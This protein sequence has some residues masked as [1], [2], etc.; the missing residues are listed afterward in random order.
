[1]DNI[2]YIKVLVFVLFLV[3]FMPIKAQQY[4]LTGV[5]TDSVTHEALSYVNVYLKGTKIGTKTNSDGEFILRTDMKSAH[6]VISSV[7]YKEF[8]RNINPAK[9]FRFRVALRPSNVTLK[10][11][12]I[13]PKREHYKKKDNPAVAFVRQMMAHKDDHSPDNHDYWSRNRYEKTLFALN[14]FTEDMQKKWIYR[15]FPFLLDYVDTS[16]VTGK[17]VLP[18]TIR[19]TV[20]SDYYRKSPNSLKQLIEAKKHAGIDEILSQ[21]G[22]E[23]TVS[24]V[25]RDVDIYKDNI[26]LFTNKF[27]SPLSRLGVD[28]Y[29]YYL[30]DTLQVDHEKCVDLAFVPFNSES[31]GFTGHFYVTLDSTY[32]VKKVVMNFPKKI[33]LNFVDYMILNQVFGRTSDGTRQLQSEDITAEFKITA[34]SDGIYA[35]R[36]VIYSNYSYDPP[37]NMFVFKKGGSTIELQDA[38]VRDDEF[39]EASRPKD[40][41]IR[42]NEVSDMMQKLRSYPVFFWTEKIL[43]V[44]FTGYIPSAKEKPKFYFGIINSSV[45]G[46]PLEG[47]RLRF[48]GMTTAW[49]DKHWFLKGFAAYGTK[50]KRFKGLAEL[51]YSFTPKKEYANEFPIRSL[52][53]HYEYD[54][55]QYGQQYLF[56]NKDNIFL[57]WKRQKNDKL[58]YIR[59]SHLTWTSEYASGFSFKL[60]A[61]REELESSDLVP[62]IQLKNPGDA[63]GTYI[64]KVRNTEGELTLR[65]A[66]HEKF[67]QTQWN[68]FPVNLDE[69]VITLTHTIAKKGF[70]D[71]DYTFNHTEFS[72]Q[73]RFWF[74]AFGYTDLMLKAGKIWDK[75]P[76][77]K[78]LYPNANLSYTIQPESYSLINAMEFAND[79]YVSWDITYFLNGW[80]FNRIPLLRKLKWREVI[81]T[82]GYYGSLSDK[83]NPTLTGDLFRFPASTRVMGKTPYAE[84]SVGI[85]NIFK[86]LRVDY[87]WRLSYRNQPGVDN[88][89]LRISV[90]MTF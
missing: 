4:T 13:K 83:N 37:Q 44:A 81:A 57:M 53:A 54:I 40:V 86:I 73:K 55:N 1:M 2:K 79:Q 3:N 50:D 88:S 25:F 29:K 24:E 56:T 22:M 77:P 30:L 84:A 85:E 15:K 9:D 23:A 59:D 28:F 62:F 19:E 78:L 64:N 69:P 21:Q 60:T 72:F 90:H 5:V 66:P 51:E 36:N 41:G 46:N 58:G 75:V 67:Y 71:S 48:G 10:E 31:F 89:G 17:P 12:V 18:I 26:T 27:V 6:L 20:A 49:V 32:F 47:T 16:A 33:N 8:S 87:T 61:R 42:T 39:W 34:K 63:D 38:T 82:R 70:L 68:R 7:G 74:S 43:Q 52:K 65:Y 14:N 35:R 80:L 76:F 11:V 45:S